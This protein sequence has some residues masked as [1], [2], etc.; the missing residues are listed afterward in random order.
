M[1][2]FLQTG[3]EHREVRGRA[4]ACAHKVEIATNDLADTR[5]KI[6]GRLLECSNAYVPVSVI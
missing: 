6:S 4:A 5:K 3:K 2:K 1:K